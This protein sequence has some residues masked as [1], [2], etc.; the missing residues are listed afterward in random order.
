MFVNIGRAAITAPK[1][2][3]AIMSGHS[4]QARLYAHQTRTSSTE[5]SDQNV[6]GKSAASIRFIRVDE[7]LACT[8]EYD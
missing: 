8:D 6:C 4:N 3:N 5:V 1:E 7:H 2:E